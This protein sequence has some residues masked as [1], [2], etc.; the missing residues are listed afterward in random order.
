MERISG[1]PPQRVFVVGC[2][3]SGTTFLQQVLAQHPQVLSLP[4]TGFFEHVIGGLDGWIDG[5]GIDLPRRFLG[6]APKNAHRHAQRILAA[7]AA[8][9]GLPAPGGRWGI[10]GYVEA[11]VDLLDR[12]AAARRRGTWV[13]KSPSHIAYVDL[14]TQCVAGARFVHVLRN[15]EDVLA[16]AVDAGLRFHQQDGG[17]GFLR[18]L[19]QWTQ[20]WNRAMDAH[21]LC[22]ARAGHHFVT[23]EAITADFAGERA[24][25][26][27]FL[28]L[29]A[30]AAAG[31]AAIAVSS[32]ER[33]PW[34]AAA[35]SGRPQT[36]RRKFESL[37]GPE[38]QCWARAELH[39]YETVCGCLRQARLLPAANEAGDR[40][41]LARM[42]RRR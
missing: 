2:P 29:S 30:T 23:Q 18:A 7:V 37:F 11:F 20:Y 42:A 13:E 36:S 19:P 41:V 31:T 26:L 40:G 25:L 12:G 22:S 6:R 14:I 34:K 39:S 35:L 33:E 17:S 32:V 27:D 9:L 24:R 8:T 16:S 1:A 3:R 5:H 21:L 10:D 4:E 15:G 38:L 28:G